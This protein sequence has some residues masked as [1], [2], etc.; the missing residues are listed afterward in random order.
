MKT[1]LSTPEDFKTGNDLV[2]SVYGRYS[3][4]FTETNDG[5]TKPAPYGRAL[6][7]HPQGGSLF[8]RGM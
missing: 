4:R 1:K 3:L 2:D 8:H 7:F 5:E 6:V